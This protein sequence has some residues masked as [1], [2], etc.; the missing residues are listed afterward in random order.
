M[1]TI[2][3]K[4]LNGPQA[5][6]CDAEDDDIRSG[7]DGSS[8]SAR[9]DSSSLFV[10]PDEETERR[11]QINS[12]IPG[13]SSNT[14]PKGVIED[15][16]KQS[17]PKKS[18]DNDDDLEAEF[19]DLLNDD[20]ILKEYISKRIAQE[21][22]K[23]IPE[24]GHMFRLKSGS[25]LLD[26]I[27]KENP[28]VLVLVHIYEKYSRACSNVDRCLDELASE[29]KHVKF[30]NLD[31]SVSGLSSNF[32]QNGLPALLAYKAGQLVKS[33]LQLE[34]FLDKDFSSTQIKELL[35]DNNLIE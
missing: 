26:A 2:E 31:A 23:D 19:R 11:T 13:C 24:F 7:E 3:D 28:S 30:V 34:E 22:S 20:S 12:K 35:I 27:D 9:A 25:E 10:R 14:G 32:R 33:L 6:Y 18:Q 4:I 21:K 17:L 8:G 16:R 29:L 15:Y 1:S 5:H